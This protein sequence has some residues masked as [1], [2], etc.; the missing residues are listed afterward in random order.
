MRQ[1]IG[2]PPFS[3]VFVPQY[4]LLS[5]SY[6]T[7]GG[8]WNPAVIEKKHIIVT[9]GFFYFFKNKRKHTINRKIKCLISIMSEKDITF[10]QVELALKLYR[11]QLSDET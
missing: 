2:H 5:F 8:L 4:I 11:C 7:L 6:S 1:E 10:Q 3:G 9:K